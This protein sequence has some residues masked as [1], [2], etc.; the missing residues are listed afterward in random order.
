MTIVEELNILV[1]VGLSGKR[2][3]LVFMANRV[4]QYLF[5]LFLVIASFIYLLLFGFSSYFLFDKSASGLL[6]L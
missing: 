6:L 3:V 1:L 2:T 5:R 4:P